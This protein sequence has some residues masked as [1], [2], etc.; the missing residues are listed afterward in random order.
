MSRES[1]INIQRS[2]TIQSH[3]PCKLD[4]FDTEPHK[5][6]THICDRMAEKRVFF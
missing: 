1:P 3:V 5:L 2:S 6:H 4:R